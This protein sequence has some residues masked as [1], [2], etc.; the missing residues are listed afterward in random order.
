MNTTEQIA[1]FRPQLQEA[2]LKMIMGRSVEL[3]E[4]G[5]AKITN[6][7]E[8]FFIESIN[9]DETIK[10]TNRAQQAFRRMRLTDI[11]L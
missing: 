8:E 1:K 2:F 10:L 3:S 4:A 9:Q 6:A 5:K 7:G 11:K